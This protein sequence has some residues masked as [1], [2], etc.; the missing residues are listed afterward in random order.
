VKRSLESHPEVAS[1]AA[2]TLAGRHN[3]PRVGAAIATHGSF[4][5]KNAERLFEHLTRELPSAALPIALLVCES[6][7]RTPTGKTDLRRCMEA[8]QRA[9]KTSTARC[10]VLD[11]DDVVPLCVEAA[12]IPA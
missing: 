5:A 7:P 9:Q 3:R 6:L 11:G 1:A 10:F 8:L 4:D 12:R 2:G